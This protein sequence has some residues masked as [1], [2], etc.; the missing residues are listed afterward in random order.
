MVFVII[1]IGAS[2]KNRVVE[3]V[4]LCLNNQQQPRFL[5]L[6]L[7][8]FKINIVEEFIPAYLYHLTTLQRLG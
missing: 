6:F 7:T 1:E 3:L 2:L 4:N 5:T 8:L